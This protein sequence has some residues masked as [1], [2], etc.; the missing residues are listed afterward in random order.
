MCIDVSF[1]FV[2]KF[3]DHS[4]RVESHLQLRNNTLHEHFFAFITICRL[5]LLRMRNVSNKSCRE[6][7]NKNF[8]FSN[9]FPNIVPFMN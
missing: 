2:Y 8:I 3:T 6:N 5:I 9:F 7:K 4:E 1:L